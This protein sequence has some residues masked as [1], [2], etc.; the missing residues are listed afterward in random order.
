MG[1]GVSFQ[2]CDWLC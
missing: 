1:K 2:W